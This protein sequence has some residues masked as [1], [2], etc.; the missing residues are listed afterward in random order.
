MKHCGKG[1]FQ[2]HN[3]REND[4]GGHS[5]G[6]DPCLLLSKEL[7]IRNSTRVWTLSI[8]CCQS[9]S[10]TQTPSILD[11]KRTRMAKSLVEMNNF[12]PPRVKGSLLVKQN[13]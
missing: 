5:E 12:K 10:K 7:V 8:H 3:L 11:I 6:D 2:T 1:D 4:P 9:Y 13:T